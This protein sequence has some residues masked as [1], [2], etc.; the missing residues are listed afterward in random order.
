MAGSTFDSLLR[1]CE[2]NRADARVLMIFASGQSREWLIAH[3]DQEAPAN[4]CE[5]FRELTEQRQQ[6]LPVAYLTGAREFFGRSFQVN[7][8][9]LVPR[10]ETELLAAYAIAHAPPDT[11]VLDLGC[12]SGALAVTIAAERP[13]LRVVATDISE[14]ALLVAA[15]NA[16]DHHCENIEFLAGSWFDAID[17]NQQFSVVVSN[18]PYIC[19]DDE[20][21]MGDGVRFEP[22]LALVSGD[23]GLSAIRTLVTQA[24]QYLLPQGRIIIE[25][26]FSQGEAVH[27]LMLANSYRTIEA[28]DDLAGHWRASSAQE[29]SFKPD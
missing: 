3:G 20:H 21:L 6:G 15:Q 14:S 22:R 9:V 29:R 8:S 27:Q 17:A 2:L 10:P 12:G 4:T 11:A 25:H 5:K 7:R 16:R 13:D 28:H 26:G 23:D 19:E 18:P 1:E 24:Q